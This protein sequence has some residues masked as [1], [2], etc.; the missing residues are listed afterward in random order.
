MSNTDS[1]PT[2]AREGSGETLVRLVRRLAK[3]HPWLITGGKHQHCI[4]CGNHRIVE[5][6]GQHAADCLWYQATLAVQQPPAPSGLPDASYSAERP[7][8]TNP[9]ECCKELSRV[10]A[11]LGITTYTGKSASEHIAS[12]VREI[13]TLKKK[14][15]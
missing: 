6:P 15:D 3:H 9:E 14:H 13:E 4:F 11:A 5:T 10:W 2:G 8:C 1:N 12:L 7:I